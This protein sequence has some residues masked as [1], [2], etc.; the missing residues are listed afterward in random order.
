MRP[1]ISPSTNARRSLYSWLRLPMLA[2][3]LVC[4]WTTPMLQLRP[5]IRFL[6]CQ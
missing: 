2:T 3:A 4:F 1:G 6:L 5:W